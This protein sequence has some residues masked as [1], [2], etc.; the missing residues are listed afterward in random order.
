MANVVKSSGARFLIVIIPDIDQVEPKK[1]RAFL[2]N[3]MGY[4]T[5]PH[6]L[7]ELKSL[8]ERLTLNLK[9]AQIAFVDITQIL[10]EAREPVFHLMD[11]H[12]NAKG[13]QLMAEAIYKK[14]SKNFKPQATQP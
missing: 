5:L 10:K 9:K 4:K 13:H 12:L 3:I 2:K 11:Q 6:R 1:F 8:K 7:Q 14:I